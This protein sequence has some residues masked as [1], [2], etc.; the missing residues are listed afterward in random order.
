M[1]RPDTGFGKS[2]HP[3]SRET[4]RDAASPATPLTWP[5]GR[6]NVHMAP[7]DGDRG[8]DSPSDELSLAATMETQPCRTCATFLR[9]LLSLDAQFW[10][11]HPSEGRQYPLGTL[12]DVGAR[13]LDG[14]GIC[15][16]IHAVCREAY[17]KYAK[18]ISQ[19]DEPAISTR[20]LFSEYRI[21]NNPATPGQFLIY[22]GHPELRGVVANVDMELFLPLARLRLGR[23]GSAHA[24]PNYL[25][26]TEVARE[27]GSP[28]CMDLARRLLHN[29]AEGHQACQ[30]LRSHL[31][32]GLT[33]LPSRVIDVSG[34]ELGHGPRLFVSNGRLG[35]YATLSHSWAGTKPLKLTSKNIEAFQESIPWELLSNTFKDAIWTTTQLGLRYLWI[36]CFGIMQDDREDWLK[37]SYKMSTIFA[38][39]TVSLCS[40]YHFGFEEGAGRLL[41]RRED[42]YVGVVVTVPDYGPVGVRRAA[43]YLEGQKVTST[44]EQRAWILQEFLLAPAVL[45]FGDHQLYWECLEARASETL[46]SHR[47]RQAAKVKSTILY[48]QVPTHVNFPEADLDSFKVRSTWYQIIAAYTWKNMMEATD[49]LIAIQGLADKFSQV[50][51]LQ[52]LHGLFAEDLHRGVL[53]HR[54]M[55]RGSILM[56]GEVDFSYEIS[57]LSETKRFP[58]L[59]APSWSWGSL[60]GPMQYDWADIELPFQERILGLDE[61]EIKASGDLLEVNGCLYQGCSDVVNDDSCPDGWVVFQPADHPDQA[62][63]CVL[64]FEDEYRSK[65]R[66][67]LKV[68]EWKNETGVLGG[69]PVALCFYLILAPEVHGGKV[70][71]S[72]HG[73]L[74]RRIGMGAT[75]SSRVKG[76]FKRAQKCSIAIV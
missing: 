52:Y 61:T 67:C 26:P 45:Y 33:P 76:L 39:S 38:N 18:A 66:A 58:E 44:V 9:D 27:A 41:R 65:E 4:I 73:P 53:W 13:V 20:V 63:P 57:L 40:L 30:S 29:C 64:D 16:I 17:Q 37:E 21:K 42:K 2:H 43:T 19:D 12:A 15:G 36:D 22:L 75:Y 7:P 11:P 48:D 55:L 32:D 34:V 25:L 23:A 5:S 72:L 14:C 8:K 60:I 6:L 31:A 51:R 56:A 54:G 3:S 71:D 62:L 70:K 49:R 50:V 69:A 46:P 68:G 47:P 10:L 74:Y 1:P 24:I 28:Q 59:H 35:L